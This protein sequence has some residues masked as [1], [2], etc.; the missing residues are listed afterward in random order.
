MFKKLLNKVVST[1]K[2]FGKGVKHMVEKVNNEAKKAVEVVK[3]AAYYK[4][5]AEVRKVD[6]AEETLRTV[7]HLFSDSYNRRQL[8]IVGLFIFAGLFVSTY[9][10]DPKEV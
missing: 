10:K 8:G 2:R 7:K 3:K 5:E 9:I 4:A 1:F 6:I